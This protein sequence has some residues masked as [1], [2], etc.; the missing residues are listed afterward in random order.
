[1]SSW[2]IILGGVTKID[3]IDGSMYASV[4]NSSAKAAIVQLTGWS[5][6]LLMRIKY[7]ELAKSHCFFCAIFFYMCDIEQT[8]KV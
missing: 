5:G 3:L 7:T 1:M 4:R 6:T 8:I 2:A